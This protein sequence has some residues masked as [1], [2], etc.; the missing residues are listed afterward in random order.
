M[1][2]RASVGTSL[3]LVLLLRTGIGHA[4]SLRNSAAEAFMGDFAPGSA[5]VYSQATGSRLGLDNVGPDSLRADFKVV[6]PSAEDLKDGYESWPAPGRIRLDPTSAEIRPGEAAP[7]EV[8]VDVPQD[9][10]FVGRQY[11]FDVLQTAADRAGSAMTLKTRVLL[12]IG[13]PL[14][15]VEDVPAAERGAMA[16]FFALTPEAATIDRISMEHDGLPSQWATVK[17]VNAGD[18]DLTVTFR[19]ARSWTKIK[20][21]SDYQTAGPNPRWL[22]FAPSVVKVPAGAIVTARVGVAVPRQPRYAAKKWTFVAAVDATAGQRR[23]RRYFAL[24]VST[25][26][27]KEELK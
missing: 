22:W 11:Q 23:A 2:R 15:S 6:L 21:D 8:Y 7:I 4:L 10:T 5:A 3:V 16:D 12:S 9:P 13:G 24:H 19:P 1:I 27:W 18:D 26:D 20:A 14:A 17:I 25:R